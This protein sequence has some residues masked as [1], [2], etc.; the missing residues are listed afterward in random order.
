MLITTIIDTVSEFYNVKIPDLQ[1]KRRQKSIAQP[2][3]VCMFLARKLTPHS[4]QEI[5]GYFGGR[6]HTTVLHAERTVEERIAKDAQF[7]GVVR[8]I[9]AKLSPSSLR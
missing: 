4:L 7:A 2:R 9:E 1:S 5:G 6:D 3:Q 8:A